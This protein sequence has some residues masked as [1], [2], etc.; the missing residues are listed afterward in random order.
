MPRVHA[1]ILAGG[2][3]ERFWPASRAAAPK[4]FLRV[5]GDRT[6]LDA[7]AARARRIATPARVWVVCGAEHERPIRAAMRLP[8]ERVLV[9]PE[10]RNTAAAVAFAALRIAAS[11]PDAVMLVLPADHF[12]PDVRAFASAIRSA[13]RAAHEARVLV[14]LGVAPTRPETGYGYIQRG[15]AVGA[16]HPGLHRVRRF[17]EKPDAARAAR[18]LRHGGYLW[19]AGIFV[20]SARQILAEI[21]RYMPDLDSAFAPLGLRRP[22]SRAAIRRAYHSAPSA[23]IDTGV[24]ERSRRVW[25][26]PVSWHWSDVGTWESLAQELGVAPGRSRQ[27]AGSELVFDDGGGNLV[28]GQPGRPVALLGVEGMAVVDTGDALLVARLDRSNDV[29]LVVKALKAQ[30]RSDVT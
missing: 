4:P 11:D 25:T 23:P 26:L 6:L 19:N 20:W 27:M 16:V 24:M 30:R 14:T 3:G 21:A 28:W 22:P 5:L 10:R 1:V 13:A 12:I 2:A 18:Y 8:R 7:T 9:E 17:V 29:R 15:A